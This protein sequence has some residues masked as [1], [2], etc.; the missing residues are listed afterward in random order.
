VFGR[1][2]SRV[3]LAALVASTL[4]AVVPRTAGATTV[5]PVTAGTAISST[6]DVW[7][8]SSYENV[9]QDATKPA[10]P[11]TSFSYVV[12]RNEYESFQIVTRSSADYTI[13]DVDFSD[14][15][16]GINSIAGT[17]LSYNF[18]EYEHL[19][20]HTINFTSL[21]GSVPGYFPDAL[22][23][24]ASA[25]VTAGKAQPI[26]VTLYVPKATVAGKYSGTATVHTTAGDLT[27][28]IYAEV[29][30]VT[31]PDPNAGSFT[32]MNHQQ[33]AGTWYLDATATSH[34]NDVIVREYGYERWTPQ[35]WALVDDMAQQ[36]RKHRVNSLF[37]N[38]QQLLLDGP[39]TM[40]GTTYTFN[41]SKFDAY[42]QRFIDA[43]VVK[44]LEGIH[45]GSTVVP[46]TSTYKSYILINDAGTMKSTNVDPSSAD[47]TNWLNQFV[48]ALYQHLVAKGWLGMWY[49]HVGDE[50]DNPTQK[51]QYA[52]YM[53]HLKADAPGMHAGDPTFNMDTANY[54]LSQGATVTIPSLDVYQQNKATFDEYLR[55]GKQVYSYNMCCV[56][57]N[58]LNRY[59]DGPVWQGRNIGWVL[60]KDGLP[61]Y[62]H[63]G[64]NFWY[65]WDGTKVTG[66][67]EQY[68]GDHFIV[69]PDTTSN[70]IKSS[71]RFEATRDMAEDYELL[72]IAGRE[73][74]QAVSTL[75]N[76]V[77]SQFDSFS[78]DVD[79]MMA[80]RAELVRLAASPAGRVFTNPVGNVANPNLVQAGG[81]YY[82]AS[83]DGNRIFIK[84]SPSLESVASVPAQYVWSNTAAGMSFTS[85]MWVSDLK[86][87]SGHWYLYFSG[88]TGGGQRT[89]VLE[90]GTDQNDPLNG[91]YT[92]KDR[93]RDTSADLVAMSGAVLVNGSSTYFLWSGI[94]SAGSSSQYLYAAP[95]SN[96]WTLSGSRSEIARPDQ[97][98][99]ATT[100]DT[101]EVLVSG[102]V[103]RVFYSAN[104]SGS[105]AS[106]IGQLTLAGGAN[107]LVKASWTKAQPAAFASYSGVSGDA[108]YGPGFPAF[109][110]S[111]D[112]TEQWMMYQ[113]R[114]FAGSGYDRVT[115]LQRVTV[116][117]DGSPNLGIP[118][119]P[120][121]ALA[122][123]SGTPAVTGIYEAEQGTV[124][125]SALVGY[126]SDASRK[127]VVYGIDTVGSSVTMTVNVAAAG[128][129][130][131]TVRNATGYT[132]AGHN[133]YIN[134]VNK[135]KLNY[136]FLGW[137][138]FSTVGM[139][140][141]LN[142][143]ANTIM[144]RK[145]SATDQYAEIDYIGIG[146]RLEAEEGV[147]SGGTL[148]TNEPQA[149][150]A[151]VAGGIDNANSAV[152]LYVNV[153]SA[154]EYALETTN[155]AL[156]SP[157]NH[158]LFINNAQTFGVWYHPNGW[159]NFSTPATNI[160]SLNAGN[161][162]I[163]YMKGQSNANI[164]FIRL[165][166]L[167]TKYE[168][169]NAA[170][171]NGAL[172]GNESTA[173]G[174]KV[175]YGI[176]NVS[177]RSSATFTVTVAAA[178]TYTI[179]IRNASGWTLPDQIMSVNGTVVAEVS[180]V[181]VGWNAFSTRSV[182]VR[183]NAGSNTITFAKS[184]GVGSN[185]AEIDFIEVRP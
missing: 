49:Q 153:P 105:D 20:A 54:S 12:A 11:A 27:V 124:S 83:S 121:Q 98:W 179:D 169:E 126:E 9:F 90:G 25:A 21:I 101:P 56:H 152:E 62:L 35:W 84:A 103:T 26:W 44:Q 47:S 50:A 127:L 78:S 85:N 67:N 15:T 161:N 17:N 33:I 97:S 70:R 93:L 43:G 119:G 130:M 183:L 140:V 117:P 163:R 6:V 168:G 2:L 19:S 39:T 77:A 133:V 55:N 145:D 57:P 167:G 120:G 181:D 48:P 157:A 162:V 123:P 51:S 155:S 66:D 28:A 92:Y 142:A 63:W 61:G 75:V 4:V 58:D 72:N 171:A 73:H 8:K 139:L 164:D 110:M 158:Y 100:V 185:T 94:P 115:R 147:L 86:F 64:W 150:G 32:S 160:V 96:P 151:A 146:D 22:S 104:N 5:D 131:M 23:N 76:S 91:A 114:R 178:G 175:A 99:E 16:S 129:Y 79:N 134:G 108:V 52:M 53:S 148:Y 111:P 132:G 170:L 135:G 68:K 36:M 137:G 159:G 40:S 184:A 65:D 165:R 177:P 182:R 128:E 154:G 112:G 102:G 138:R 174:G 3:G 125:G 14:L 31:I 172:V 10:N 1:F 18:V 113:A 118:W 106:A 82:L 34:P 38:T 37:V 24:A 46:D 88:D 95:M 116:N 176:D 144:F 59:I 45:F 42:I 13:T 180:Y 107:P 60:Y 109:A 156:N 80:K 122:A 74:Q 87:L 149:S 41:W 30:N 143:G 141:T 71:I 69:Y 29:A 7:T 89:H 136:P 173:S 81:N 166:K